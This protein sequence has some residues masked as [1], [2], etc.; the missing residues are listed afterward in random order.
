MS[1]TVLQSGPYRFF[2][3][4]SDRGEPIH[5]HVKR[6]R[7]LAKFWLA[8]VRIAYNYGFSQAELKR[9]ADIARKHEA[10]LSKA[11]HDYFKRSDANG[12]GSERPRH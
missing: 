6:D 4:S 10:E 7:R 3:F 12:G 8:P 2:F 1:P 9:I 5:V 11:W